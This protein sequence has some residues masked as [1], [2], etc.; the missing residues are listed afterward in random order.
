MSAS[1]DEP[2]VPLRYRHA[3]VFHALANWYRDKKDDARMEAAKGEYTDL[4]LR[5]VSDVEVGGVRP[6][7]RPRMSEYRRSANRPWGGRSFTPGS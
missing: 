1:T 4:M 7:I 5:I 2:I 3:L 6:Q